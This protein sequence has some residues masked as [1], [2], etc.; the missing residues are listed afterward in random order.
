MGAAVIGI[1]A[2][3]MTGI[4][5]GSRLRSGR[6]CHAVGRRMQAHRWRTFGLDVDA[7]EYDGNHWAHERKDGSES[8]QSWTIEKILKAKYA[9]SNNLVL[10]AK[11]NR[12]ESTNSN[13]HT[14]LLAPAG[15]TPNPRTH[16]V[17]LG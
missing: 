13:L 5:M 8:R 7:E 17:C 15:Q 4:V 1:A 9:S 11:A 12:S 14:P 6:M 2:K 10:F 3:G 16:F